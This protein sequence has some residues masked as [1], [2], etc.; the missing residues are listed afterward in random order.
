MVPLAIEGLARTSTQAEM[1]ASDS[2]E[3]ALPIA[4]GT[5]FDADA[6]TQGR[7]NIDV[8]RGPGPRYAQLAEPRRTVDALSTPRAAPAWAERIIRSPSAAALAVALEASGRP[9]EV[10]ALGRA[11]ESYDHARALAVAL[12]VEDAITRVLR[13][14]ELQGYQLALALQ[15]RDAV[16]DFRRGSF[17]A[18]LP[19]QVIPGEARDQ[20]DVREW[21]ASLG[22]DDATV[23]RLG[24]AEVRTSQIREYHAAGL[25]HARYLPLLEARVPVATIRA[26]LAGFTPDEHANLEVSRD[27]AAALKAGVAPAFVTR[28]ARTFGSM[29][30]NEVLRLAGIPTEERAT[31]AIVRAFAHR[32][33]VASLMDRIDRLARLGADRATAAALVAAG[34]TPE[35]LAKHIT[36]HRGALSANAVARLLVTEGGAEELQRVGTGHLASYESLG[37]SR[38]EAAL[39]R[40]SR[41]SADDIVVA[42]I[43]PRFFAHPDAR[44]WKPAGIS[45]MQLADAARLAKSDLVPELVEAF[46][47][48]ANDPSANA[49]YR[50]AI[51]VGASALTALATAGTLDAEHARGLIDAARAWPGPAGER[52]NAI[53]LGVEALD[54]VDPSVVFRVVR[55]G[56]LP[57]RLEGAS[58]AD[59]ELRVAYPSLA[60]KG[61]SDKHLRTLR[62][63]EVRPASLVGLPPGVLDSHNVNLLVRTLAGEGRL[64]QAVSDMLRQ[65]GLSFVSR[66]HPDVLAAMLDHRNRE[67]PLA[68]FVVP[69]TDHNRVFD[70]IADVQPA[71]LAYYD[72]R[73]IEAGRDEELVDRALRQMSG[74][75]RISLLVIGGHGSPDSIRLGRGSDQRDTIDV[76]DG[77]LLARLRPALAPEAAVVLSSCST[78]R[79]EGR[80][81]PSVARVIARHIGTRVFAPDQDSA[82]TGI[83]V[84][85]GRVTGVRFSGAGTRVFEPTD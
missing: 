68:V 57:D 14:N 12:Q 37:L 75:R 53:A 15:T 4:V 28:F 62:A 78:G 77:Q 80:N 19:R 85:E 20:R 1:T 27:A 50:D 18:T 65:T 47:T 24:G 22:I 44:R 58:V 11:A 9:E 71:L 33:R 13:T 21:L 42:G 43:P 49:A 82:I 38:H 55:A 23:Q 52:D 45:A 79:E 76:G 5:V 30:T 64:P 26:Y 35:V 6:L 8:L 10:A 60:N 48:I 54:G 34:V 31:D 81:A 72:V 36:R 51:A 84:T 41:Y 17:A 2:G 61:W 70:D 39:A 63:L 73:V 40:L 74:G 56:L 25:V 69:S 3:E 59:I 46:A 16:R 32:A 66:V 29:P 67:R 83:D 7:R